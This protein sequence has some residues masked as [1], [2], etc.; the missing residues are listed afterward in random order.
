MAPLLQHWQHAGPL[1]NHPLEVA[2]VILHCL[3]PPCHLLQ[4][5]PAEQ[6]GVT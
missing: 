6:D 2:D 1:D 4:L 3:G 5:L